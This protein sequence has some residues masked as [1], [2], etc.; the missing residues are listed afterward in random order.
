MTAM[1]PANRL[2]GPNDNI[3]EILQGNERI[4]SYPGTSQFNHDALGISACG[5]AA[6][7]FAR[8]VSDLVHVNGQDNMIDLLRA[9]TSK[10]VIQDIMSI[11]S[12]WSSELHLDVE[13]IK[14]I[15]LFEN[16]LKHV[17]TRFGPPKPKQF[18]R[19]LEY[20]QNLNTSSTV[21]ITRPP[22]II[23]CTMIKGL[24]T[25]IFVIFDSH[26]RPS[27]PA[28]AG[29]ILN[30]S[31]DKVISRLTSILPAVD[32][33]LFSLSGL[34]WQA[35]LLNHVS[36][37]VFISNGPP[38]DMR[39]MQ[40]TVVESS[41]AVLKIRAEVAVLLQQNDRLTKENEAL[42]R[43][44]QRLGDALNSERAKVASLQPPSKIMQSNCER[45]FTAGPLP[46]KRL[47]PPPSSLRPLP[48]SSRPTPS[49]SRPSDGIAGPSWQPP[50]KFLCSPSP[51]DKIM[52]KNRDA[53]AWSSPYDT[54]KGNLGNEWGLDSLS[55]AAA[56]EL[57]QSFDAEDLQLRYQMQTLAA[58]LP[59]NFSCLICMEDQP[60]DNSVDLGCNHS[61][62][63]ACIRGHICSKIEEHRFPILCP[64]CMT[65]K[66]N[67][68]PE[69][70]SGLLV[71]QIGVDER[72]YAIWEDM[73]LS[74]LSVLLHCRKCQ[75]SVPV[76]KQEHDESSMLV[77]PLP[78]CNHIWCKACQ[79][80][81][82][83][84]GPPHS[85][86]GTSELDHLMKQRG[87]KYCPNCKTP[88]QRDGGC[89][90][91]TCISPACNTHFCYVCGKSIVRSALRDDI[92]TAVAAHYRTCNLFDYT[93]E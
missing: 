87:W 16:S 42:E 3:A 76:D 54:V 39:G 37:H 75:R 53:D 18:M 20:M 92:Q 78:D 85:C 67:R 30:T 50:V 81:F 49:S 33:D 19:T 74:Q 93:G 64:V 10:E 29:L 86:D 4:V 15:P 34:Q 68:Q 55:S 14:Q 25:N 23:A 79:Q 2:N 24:E 38:A 40:H 9:I 51:S 26:P 57:Q 17:T 48:S 5:L 21:I 69:A 45:H 71:Q 61:I 35:Q 62:C 80:S 7:N 13:D 63:R 11:C 72:Q 58:S 46:L 91:M 44:V 90:H 8:V 70:I 89:S 1:V 12:G 32:N 22:E 28:G 27:Y 59:H 66:N 36:G 82:V 6:M 60:V 83:I 31:I 41:L 84:G 73:E 77:C 47:Q 52:N 88:V 43:E 56:F 65:E